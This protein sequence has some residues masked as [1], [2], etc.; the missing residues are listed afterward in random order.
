MK[1]CKVLTSVSGATARTVLT[2]IMSTKYP[3]YILDSAYVS[4]KCYATNISS[5][6]DKPLLIKGK[7][8][9]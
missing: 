4:S 8:E 3:K 2:F 5:Q 1:L 7:W 9:Y 6:A